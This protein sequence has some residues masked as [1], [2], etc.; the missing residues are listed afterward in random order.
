MHNEDLHNLYSSQNI[1][2]MIKSRRMKWARH[3][4]CMRD[5]RNVYRIFV[6][7]PEGKRTLERSTRR[8][9]NTKM[10][11]RGSG[12]QNKQLYNSRC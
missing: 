8:W 5:Y 7:N 9:D 11:L 10:G 1:I 4:A 12:P 2:R 3:I 6:R